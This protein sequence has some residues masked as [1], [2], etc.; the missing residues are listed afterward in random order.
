MR[1]SYVMCDGIEFKERNPVVGRQ[2]MVEHSRGYVRGTYKSCDQTHYLLV[3]CAIYTD[4]GKGKGLERQESCPRAWGPI[5]DGIL[6][7]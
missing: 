7:H 3:D 1:V 5:R 2:A 6:V 4:F